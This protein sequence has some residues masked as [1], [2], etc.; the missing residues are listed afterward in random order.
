LWSVAATSAAGADLPHGVARVI[1]G[2][3]LPATSYGLLVQEVGAD[4]ALISANAGASLNPA[5]VMKLVTTF[6]ALETL[7][8]TYTWQTEVYLDGTL[9]GGTLSGDLV[10]KGYGDPSM[11]TEE[12]WRLLKAL[13]RRGL[14]TITGDLLIDNSH[15][16][17]EPHD[18][19]KF[20]GQGDRAYNVGPDAL[21]INYQAVQ[22]YFYPA[23]DGK[24]VRVETDPEL[25]NVQIDNQLGLTSDRCAGYQR[26]VYFDAQNGGTSAKVVV[27]GKFPAACGEY[28]LT[29]SLLTPPS[30]AY[31][32]FQTLWRE[33]GGGFQGKL[34]TTVVK[35]G[36]RPFLTWSSRPLRDVV[37]SINKFSNNVMARHLLL[38]V[39]VE[40]FGT[41][42]TVENGIRA[43][44][45]HLRKQGF[46]I[47]GLKVENGSGLSR[48]TRVSAQLL[49]DL[50]QS[51]YRSAFMPEYVASLSLSGYDGTMRRRF[52]GSHEAGRM[53]VKTGSMDDIAAV[54]GY[55]HAKS[56]KRYV[57]VGLLNH[58]NA[59][60]GPGQELMDALLNW[61]FQQ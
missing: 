5:S 35:P 27:S 48:E 7:G 1:Q 12:F 32:L 46:D 44:E 36:R 52:A 41:P 20:D 40:H 37:A 21:L 60:R 45:E 61:T 39:G 28:L 2:H 14:Q 49:A 3:A 6:V 56:G 42:A 19:A 8:P 58:K 10:L 11:V 31:G 17:L 38:T 47:T 18:P 16:M 30:Y 43:I 54:A 59:H 23:A 50:L 15:F 57:V 4:T 24:H 34:R 22:F 9:S 26:G 29:R 51:A 13:R 55:V 33:V 25:A 53:H